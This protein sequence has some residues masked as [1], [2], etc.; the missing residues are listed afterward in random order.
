MF[1]TGRYR[2]IGIAIV[3]TVAITLLFF[4][5]P[6]SNPVKDTSEAP[7]FDSFGEPGQTIATTA[8]EGS[9]RS[10]EE[11]MQSPGAYVLDEW[12]ASWGAYPTF[13]RDL[14]VNAYAAYSETVL[15]DLAKTGDPLANHELGLRLIWSALH[16]TT[17]RPD[18]ATLWDADSNASPLTDTIDTQ[19]LDSGRAYLY[20]AALGGRLNALTEIGLSFAY[21]RIAVS[22]HGSLSDDDERELKLQT[23]AYGEMPER[24]IDGLHASFFQT[25]LPEKL[26]YEGEFLLAN[27][28]AM[29]EEDRRERGYENTALPTLPGDLLE[30]LQ[31]CH[32]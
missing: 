5:G 9:C 2:F 21:Q 6:E 20:Q 1:S 30:M 16:G 25:N 15:A 18:G 4:L 26:L 17:S 27:R 11:L 10:F 7:R 24:L 14:L 19:L 8:E 29:F 3:A 12:F 28:M 23:F 32:D 31:I 22:R 13:N